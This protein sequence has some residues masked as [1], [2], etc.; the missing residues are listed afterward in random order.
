MS[1]GPSNSEVGFAPPVGT[2]FMILLR[3]CTILPGFDEL[4]KERTSG[5]SS[6]GH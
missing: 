2:L 3:I 4:I 6:S 5:G 1:G